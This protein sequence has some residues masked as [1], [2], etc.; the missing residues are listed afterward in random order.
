ME[1]NHIFKYFEQVKTIILGNTNEI[2]ISSDDTLYCLDL[3]LL[4]NDNGEIFPA[5]K[6]ITK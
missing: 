4:K 3:S 2:S 1:N 5:T 6:F